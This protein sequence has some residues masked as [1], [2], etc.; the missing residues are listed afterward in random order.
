MSAM[1][2]AAA[3]PARTKARQEFFVVTMHKVRDRVGSVPHSW[4]PYGVQHAWAP[5]TRKTLCGEWISGWTVFWELPFSAR[6]AE[7]CPACIEATL[8][9]ESRRRLDSLARPLAG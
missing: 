6:L 3:A 9:D 7:S 4:I 1:L 5:G 8:P 2:A